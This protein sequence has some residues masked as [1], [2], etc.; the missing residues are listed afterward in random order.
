MLYKRLCLWFFLILLFLSGCISRSESNIQP[1][2][3]ATQAEVKPTQTPIESLDETAEVLVYPSTPALDVWDDRSV[4]TQTLTEDG[5]QVLGS[6]PMASVYHL[7]LVIPEDLS[8]LLTGSLDVR[9][10][11]QEEEPLTEIY[12]RLFPNFYGGQLHVQDVSVDDRPADTQLE[13]KDTALRVDLGKPLNPG[14]SIIISLQFVLKLP[15]TM[16]GNYGL[17]GYFEEILVLDTFYPMIPAYDEHGWYAHYPYQNGDLTYMDASF[18]L[19]EVAAPED[20][21]LASSGSVV[22]Q[23]VEDGKQQLTIASGPARDFY[24]AGS[25]KFEVMTKEVD[26]IVVNSYALEGRSVMQ[27]LALQFAGQALQNFNHL[28]GD[29]PYREFDVVSSPMQA[30][31]IEYPGITGIFMNLYDEHGSTY[32]LAN[33]NMIE[34]V[35]AHEVGHQWFYN[36]VGNDQQSEPWVDESLTQYV[37]YQ[38]F[39]HEYGKGPALGLVQNWDDRWARVEYEKM[40]IGLPAGEYGESAYSPIVYGRGPLFYLELEEQFGEEVLLTWIRNFS[41]AYRWKVADTED[42]RESLE[43]ACSCDLSEMF[44]EWIYPDMD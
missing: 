3:T 30:L 23:R 33:R 5:Q 43:A 19:V 36:L 40:P 6:L 17:L 9:Y 29:Y 26:G 25:K 35:I 16:G 12:F 2:V 18:Y 20:L 44:E 13:S 37:T 34:S 21:I 7:S 28:F 42:V 22:D 15:E 14:E 31:G 8:E 24:L 39:V 4:F 11:N 27:E 32:G 10:F 1:T 41:Q 38:Y